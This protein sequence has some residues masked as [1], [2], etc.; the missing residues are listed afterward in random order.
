M[1]E[2][3]LLWRCISNCG[4]C[5]RL[6]P[7]ERIESIEALSEDQAKLYLG[8]VDENGWCKNYDVTNRM[9]RIYDQR[10][11]FCKVSSLS[12]IFGIANEDA[13][14]FAIKCCIEHISSIYGT[15]SRVMQQFKCEVGI[16]TNNDE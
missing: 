14:M 12:N 8:M 9:C 15:D 6:A 1:N 3:P 5:C 11:D 2:S 16:S 7:D 4:A 13:D 10:P